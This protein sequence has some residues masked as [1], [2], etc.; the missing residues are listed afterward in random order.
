MLLLPFRFWCSESFFAVFSTAFFVPFP[1]LCAKY[2][3]CCCCVLSLP[4]KMFINDFTFAI[5]FNLI[6]IYFPRFFPSPSTFPYNKAQTTKKYCSLCVTVRHC[7]TKVYVKKRRRMKIENWMAGLKKVDSG[8]QTT[9]GREE[10]ERKA[11]GNGI[12]NVD[13]FSHNEF[14]FIR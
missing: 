13:L 9:K 14:L 8:E 3:V 4:L 10:K 6:F 12:M 5:L 11:F 1:L 2:F 7:H